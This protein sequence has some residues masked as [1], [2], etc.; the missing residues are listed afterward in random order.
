LANADIISCS[1]AGT[2]NLTILAMIAFHPSNLK[3][4]AAAF[5]TAHS[6]MISAALAV[7]VDTI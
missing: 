3:A 6:I 1:D 4:T 7:V 2:N 5:L